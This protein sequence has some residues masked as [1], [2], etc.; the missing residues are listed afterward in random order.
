M[1]RFGNKNTKICPELIYKDR[2]YSDPESVTRCFADY[3]MNLYSE[4]VND[5]FD[6]DMKDFID[7]WYKEIL[8]SCGENQKHLPGGSITE[9][10]VSDAIRQLKLKKA[11]GPDKVQ[12]EHLKY[13]GATVVRFLCV[14][15]NNV[16]G[17]GQIPSS[18]KQGLLVPIYKGGN[19]KRTLPESY[20][21]VSL[22]SSVLKLFEFI[23][24]SRLISYVFHEI[25]FACA[26]QQGFQKHLSC[27]TAS[28]NL[29]DSIY[30]TFEI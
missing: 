22:L 7:R 24:K 21:P 25:E 23:V 20:R 13:G 16:V 18:W 6:K 19:K 2:I 29:L 1:K 10:E 5:S 30:Y 11:A 28:F 8:L 12:N 27:I 26:Q 9:R 17:K 15:F 4:K 3:Y 14:L